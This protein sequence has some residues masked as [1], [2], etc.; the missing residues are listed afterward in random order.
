MKW[1]EPKNP[2]GNIYYYTIEWTLHD[3]TH[4][5]NVTERSFRFPNVKFSDRFNITVRAIGEGGLGNPLHSS[6]DRWKIQ[7]PMSHGSKFDPFM[8]FVIILISIALVLFVVGLVLCKQN[9]Y[10]KNNSNGIIN[11][12]QSSFSP[13]SPCMEN[14][15]IRNDE[16]FEMQT[17]IPISQ[18]NIILNGKDNS[19]KPEI[20][21]PSPNGV[22]NEKILRTSTPTG[23]LISV[24]PIELPPIKVDEISSRQIDEQKPN[25][26]IKISTDISPM[27]LSVTA[28]NKTI[29]S[30]GLMNPLKVNGNTSPYKTLQVCKI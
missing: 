6:S 10:C 17:L 23:E 18:N 16:M 27:I 22:S 5:A 12:E 3:V 1:N 24:V 26:T 8:I 28:P 20:L 11:S 9:R 14:N 15:M 21:V 25:G 29:R 4:S 13:T 7:S 19:I 2:N 30:I